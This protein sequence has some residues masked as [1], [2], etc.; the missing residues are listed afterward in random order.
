MIH[1]YSYTE[2]G[3]GITFREKYNDMQLHSGI[4]REI[5]SCTAGLFVAASSLWQ[6]VR[7]AGCSPIGSA[8]RWSPPAWEWRGWRGWGDREVGTTP[9][10]L[11]TGIETTCIR[12]Y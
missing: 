12:V 1:S 7:R 4:P 11:N 9:A 10:N 6:R 8:G 5:E 3:L 2:W